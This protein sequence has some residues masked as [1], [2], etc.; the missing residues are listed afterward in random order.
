MAT[1]IRTEHKTL[2]SAP[3][4]Q[5]HS[6]NQNQWLASMNDSGWRVLTDFHN[7]PDW[8]PSVTEAALTDSDS[9]ARGSLL[10]ISFAG[11]T[12]L[13]SIDLWDPP[14]RIQLSG[15][16]AGVET[17]YGFLIRM[18]PNKS[19]LEISLEIERRLSGLAQLLAGLIRWRQQHWG[20]R[21]VSNL[22]DR[23]R[24]DKS[25]PS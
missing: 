22:G 23:I 15:E 13:W 10:N 16:I 6:D 8:V 19:Q 9:P 5:Q 3:R 12:A 11:S 17:A 7:W 14:Q 21:M 2:I 24:P 20:Q 25:L 1:I 4:G 18:N